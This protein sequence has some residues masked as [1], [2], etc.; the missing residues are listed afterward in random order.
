MQIFARGQ[1]RAGASV[2]LNGS[3][4]KCAGVC[5]SRL[6][7]Q[8]GSAHGTGVAVR[9]GRRAESGAE[10][11]KSEWDARE[12]E[13]GMEGE[14]GDPTG[15]GVVWRRSLSSV[16]EETMLVCG[17]EMDQRQRAGKVRD[18]ALARGGGAV[19]AWAACLRR[20]ANAFARARL[21]T[22]VQNLQMRRLAQV[23]AVG[24]RLVAGMF[25]VSSGV[26]T[27]AHERQRSDGHKLRLRSLIVYPKSRTVGSTT[28]GGG[29][30]ATQRASHSSLSGRRV[31]A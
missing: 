25:R 30:S 17:G 11:T 18:F 24:A 4:W 20:A 19:G 16:V 6:D 12:A 14:V 8:N 15:G 9:T 23:H 31:S 29:E 10:G 7:V 21:S 27:K 3:V 5:L 1:G 2:E 28:V 26:S 22:P 13:W